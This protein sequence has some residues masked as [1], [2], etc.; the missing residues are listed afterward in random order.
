[1]ATIEPGGKVK[2]VVTSEPNTSKASKTLARVFLK[3]PQV[4]K[5][6]RNRRK[7]IDPRIRAGRIWAVRPKG[8]AL[9]PP[10]RGE[11]C[12]INCT[13]DVARDLESVKQYVEV[14]PV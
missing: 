1:M 11:S 5:L 6:R 7:P 3:D 14:A 9:W 10:A 12:E 13:L 4:K 2:V 8:S